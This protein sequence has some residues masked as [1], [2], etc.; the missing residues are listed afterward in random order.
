MDVDGRS[1]L[2]ITNIS[3]TL[4]VVGIS[5]FNDDVNLQGA[6]AGVTSAYWDKSANEFKFIDNAKLSFGTDQDL[7]LYHSSGNS[8]VKNT[9][10]GSLLIQ[11][12]TIDLRPGSGDTG[13]VMLRAVRNAQVELRHDNSA[14]FT[15]TGYGVSVYGGQAGIGTL[16]APAIFHIDPGTVGDDTG[17]VIIKG[18]LQ[19]DGTQLL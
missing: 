9:T 3:E 11:G 16:G 1:E 14:R 12:D 8:Y 4:N 18:N 7:E 13:E 17:T 5:T 15:T 19:V 6:N 2:D 10:A